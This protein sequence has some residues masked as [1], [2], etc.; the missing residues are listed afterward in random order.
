MMEA[1]LSMPHPPAPHSPPP[2]LETLSHLLKSTGKGRFSASEDERTRAWRRHT[3]RLALN[4]SASSS[5]SPDSDLHQHEAASNSLRIFVPPHPPHTPCTP[6]PNKAPM[7]TGLG[8]ASHLESLQ[9]MRNVVPPGKVV[10][11]QAERLSLPPSYWGRGRSQTLTHT[12]G[13]AHSHYHPHARLPPAPL[14]ARMR[15]STEAYHSNSRLLP[16]PLRYSPYPAPVLPR[17][18]TGATSRF[19]SHLSAPMTA[20]AATGRNRSVSTPH[21]PALPPLLRAAESSDKENEGEHDRNANDKP[22]AYS[23]MDLRSLTNTTASCSSS[24]STA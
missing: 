13:L 4:P 16:P 6:T 5:S 23:P 3:I 21:Y 14:S 8:S 12:H 24:P 17:P 11:S 10:S 18:Q 15:S 2:S 19:G 9:V 22:R 7:Y 20:G 1:V